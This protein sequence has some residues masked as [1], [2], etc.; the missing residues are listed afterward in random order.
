MN[1]IGIGIVGCGNISTSYLRLIPNF[2]ALEIKA[3]T[4]RNKQAAV[5]QA[6]MMPCFQMGI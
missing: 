6:A 4:G 5:A 2:A 3:I 1:K